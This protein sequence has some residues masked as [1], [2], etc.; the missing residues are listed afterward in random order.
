MYEIKI[1][2]SRFFF[3]KL[4]LH[5]CFLVMA[6]LNFNT[7]KPRQFH[8]HPRYYDERKERLE[9]MKAR[10]KAEIAAEKSE[11]QYTGLQ[12]GFLSESRENSKIR[13]NILKGASN[14][15]ILRYLL[16]LILL[17]GIFYVLTPEVF[18][19]FWKIKP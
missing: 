8:Y 12:V 18:L 5:L 9:K 4:F 13:R 7:P 10:A 15:R 1:I 14:A 6:L 3:K 11:A 2:F 19:A 16:I 17:M